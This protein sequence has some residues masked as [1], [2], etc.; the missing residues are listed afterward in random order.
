LERLSVFLWHKVGDIL[1]Y[2]IF[3][4]R[5]GQFVGYMTEISREIPSY[6]QQFDFSNLKSKKQICKYI[7]TAIQILRKHLPE[8]LLLFSETKIKRNFA[9]EK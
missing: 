5:K 4:S 9:S 3:E 8:Q 6:V 7:D 1:T 2:I